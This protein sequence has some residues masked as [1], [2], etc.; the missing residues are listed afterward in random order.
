MT[1]LHFVKSARKADKNAGIKK[2]DSY[3]WWQFA[4][5]SKRKSKTRPARSSYETQSEFLGAIYDIE[6]RL[7]EITDFDDAQSERDSIVDELRELAD[8]CEEKRSNMPDQL[9]DSGSGEILSN[10][11]DSCNEFADEL[12]GIDLE[13]EKEDDESDED[14][15]ERQNDALSELQNVSYSGE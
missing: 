13:I 15:E 9:Q 8:Q 11:V 4:F 6:D 5:G 3:Y 1:R 12:E 10:R 14:F 7:A 2:G